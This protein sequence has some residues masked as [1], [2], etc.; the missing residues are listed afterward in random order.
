MAMAQDG[1]PMIDGTA[2][3]RDLPA[4]VAAL[5]ADAGRRE[6]LS[7]RGRQLVDGRGAERVCAALRELAR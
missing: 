5:A 1:Y 6:A 3:A 7:R 4:A 2:V